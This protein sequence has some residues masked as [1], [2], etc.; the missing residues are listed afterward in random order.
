M[1]YLCGKFGD[2]SFS[3]FNFI[4]KTQ[5]DNSKT[6]DRS[7]QTSAS[8]IMIRINFVTVMFLTICCQSAIY[9]KQCDEF[10]TP[11]EN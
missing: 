3:H 5:T 10:Q 6:D 8:V 1:D 11:L 7:T 9:C 4:V 2:C